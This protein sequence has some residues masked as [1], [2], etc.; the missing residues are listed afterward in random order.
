MI[1]PRSHPVAN[2]R[3][4]G[5]QKKAYTELNRQ[6]KQALA[7]DLEGLREHMEAEFKRIADDHS[8]AV[9][10]VRN[11][12][13]YAKGAKRKARP[14]LGNALVS[15]KAEELNEGMLCLYILFQSE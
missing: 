1:P 6:K 10:R 9:S 3:R 11:L 2:V 15:H 14:S 4:T 5:S 13:F 7:D 8:T 12:F